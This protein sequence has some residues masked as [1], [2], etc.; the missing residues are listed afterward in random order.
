ME[1][2]RVYFDYVDITGETLKGEILSIFELDG[3]DK[4]YAICSV[5][6]SD[7]EYDIIP[8]ILKENGESA[9]SLEDITDQEELEEVSE[10]TKYL[11]KNDE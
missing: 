8:F 3:R 7:G 5:P 4:Q 1:E 11:I 10:A 2:K 6:T 9:V